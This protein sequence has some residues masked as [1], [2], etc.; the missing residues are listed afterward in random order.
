MGGD[1][2]D[3]IPGIKGIGEKTAQKLLAEYGTL[4]NVLEHCEDIKQNSLREK[5]VN[6]KEIAKL[7]QKL[8]TIIRDVDINFDFDKAEVILPDINKVSEFLRS[9]Q[10]YSFIKNINKILSTFGVKETTES[11]PIIEQKP[12]VNEEAG[13]LG[14]FTQ[15]MKDTVEDIDFKCKILSSDEEVKNVINKLASAPFAINTYSEK[16]NILGFPKLNNMLVVF[17]SILLFSLLLLF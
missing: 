17:T 3:N 10:F 14:L 12:I 13:Q 8:A 6:G 9:M 4:D 15:A 11:L 16:S 7:S 2:S 5:L 1:K